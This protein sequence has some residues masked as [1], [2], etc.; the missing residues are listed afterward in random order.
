AL[1]PAAAAA[2]PAAAAAAV[3]L[4]ISSSSGVEA[5]L[6]ASAAGLMIVE[7]AAPYVTAAGA[8]VSGGTEEAEEKVESGVAPG[9]ALA[10]AG[11]PV[12]AE[13]VEARARLGSSGAQ[14]AAEEAGTGA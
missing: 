3:V 12:E 10:G 5:S 7:P 9:E 8:R 6:G 14:A 2:A 11:E 4:D 13:T 1:S